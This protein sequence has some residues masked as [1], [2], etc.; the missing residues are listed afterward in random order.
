MALAEWLFIACKRLLRV[1]VLLIA[2]TVIVVNTSEHLVFFLL[3]T[4]T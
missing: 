1:N 4:A 2:I 3:I